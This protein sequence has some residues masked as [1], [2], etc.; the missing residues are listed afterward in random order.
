MNY[1]DLTYLDDHLSFI[2]SRQGEK[3]LFVVGWAI[4]D[5]L[6]G[7]DRTPRDIDITCASDPE[8]IYTQFEKTQ[9]DDTSLFRTE[10]FG[11]VTLIKNSQLITHSSQSNVEES[12]VIQNNTESFVYEL[13]PFREESWYDDHRHPDQIAWSNSLLADAK[14]R[15][16]TIN[17]LYYTHISFSEKKSKAKNTEEVLD[18]SLDEL[19]KRG[20][21]WISQAKLII[22]QDHTLI[23]KFFAE[24]EFQEKIFLAWAEENTIAVGS[25]VRFLIDP[26][27][28]IQDLSEWVLR[29]VGDAERRFHEDALRILRWVRL[30][31]ILNQK[32]ISTWFDFHK[33]TWNAMKKLSWLVSWLAK[34]RLH[35][36]IVKVFTARNPFGW[37]A[38]IDELGLLPVLFPAL[39]RN[40]YDEQPI[41]YHP[42]DTYT[43]ILLTLWHL[44]K[45][46]D[47]YL[48][49]L[50][51]LYHDVGKK[52]QYAEYAKATTKEQMQEIHSSP[53]N[54]VISWPVFVEE[55][56]RALGFSNKE[57]DEVKL[58]VAQH[59]RPWQILMAR[60]DNQLKRV[61]Q[62]LSEFG[63]ERVKNLFDITAA[64]RQG[65][66]NPLQSHEIDAVD[67]LYEMLEKLNN[68]EWQFTMR[69]LAI[70]GDD[71]MNEFSLQPWPQIKKYLAQAFEWVLSDIA[72]RNHKDTIMSY[73]HTLE[74]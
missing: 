39:A 21:Y 43:H 32:L 48:V 73:L 66:Y 20:W 31:N 49:K 5:I 50:G 27:W 52:D 56:F 18:L 42:F 58:Y 33:E 63:Y 41:R 6:L 45:I 16:F 65:Q 44:Q 35:Q 2:V 10:K 24:G 71:I 22:V 60:P 11:T 23:E 46:N 57:I 36:E 28:G 47:N 13:T 67:G 40:K 25:D 70:D 37:V 1:G 69:D 8:L 29:A 17:C 38:L 61:R 72:Q 62:M 4:R 19:T 30:V 59:M 34:E 12:S 15:D 64:D 54:H 3:P 74:A 68:E 9:T 53:A 7:V 55:D 26:F 14:R 51:M